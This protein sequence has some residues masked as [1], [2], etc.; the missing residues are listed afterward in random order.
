MSK[1][2]PGNE[3]GEAATPFEG[4]GGEDGIRALVKRFYDL[5]DDGAPTIRA[6]LPADDTVSRQKLFEY[7][8]EWTGGPA[9]YTP[10]RGHPVMRRR[11]LPFA[12]GPS[13]VAEW[14]RCFFQAMDDSAVDGE[15]RSYLD[16]R[17]EALAQHMQNVD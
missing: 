4:L 15:L 6:M 3:W 17:I 2:R 16:I 8:T 10:H 14:L 11:H 9:L 13:E 1:D 7:L 12:I 5:V